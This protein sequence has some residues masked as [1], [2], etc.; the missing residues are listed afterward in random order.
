[1]FLS[2]KAHLHIH[3]TDGWM[4]GFTI[5][6]IAAPKC[7]GVNHFHDCLCR[8]RKNGKM[9]RKMKNTIFDGMTMSKYFWI[10]CCIFSLFDKKQ[11]FYCIVC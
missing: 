9:E 10:L 5:K 11:F 1:M 4:P 3:G 8:Q 2:R 6:L 7:E